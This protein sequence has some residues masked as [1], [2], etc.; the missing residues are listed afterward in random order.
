MAWTTKLLLMTA[1]AFTGIWARVW[2]SMFSKL[3]HQTTSALAWPIFVGLQLEAA[4]IWI[5]GQKR[6]RQKSSILNVFGFATLVRND[7]HLNLSRLSFS[8]QWPHTLKILF[9]Y[10]PQLFSLIS[11]KFNFWDKELWH[12]TVRESGCPCM[13]LCNKGEGSL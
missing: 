1:L 9:S 5:Q 11:R 8:G 10:S 2:R 4:G 12:K 6:W 7:F 13:V 3:S